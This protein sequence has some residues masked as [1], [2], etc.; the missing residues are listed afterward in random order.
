MTNALSLPAALRDRP[1]APRAVAVDLPCRRVFGLDVAATTSD[2]AAA[3]VMALVAG[4]GHGKFAF[5][6]A[7]AANLAW[8]D[9]RFHAALR[10]FTIFPDG[11]GIDMAARLLHGAPFPENLNG[12]DFVPHLLKRADRPLTVGLLGARPGVVAKARDRFATAF[13]AHA[14]RIVHHGYFD[15]AVMARI[16]ERLAERPVDILLVA[17]GN[18]QQEEFIAGALDGR[19]CRAA[20]G[21]GALFDF[22]SG[23]VPRAPPLM[24]DLRVEWLFRLNREPGRMWRRYMVGNPV[25][26]LRVLRERWR[27]DRSHG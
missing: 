14:F 16:A 1:T 20:F 7:H 13:P 3:A 21:I 8:E 5:L 27:R 12:T 10:A 6:N 19:H 11:V 4:G 9:A 2:E 17:L 23:R 18:P 22:T 26:V 25:F 24:R 15:A